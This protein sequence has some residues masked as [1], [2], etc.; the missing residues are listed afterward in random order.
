LLGL[1]G[2]GRPSPHNLDLEK[3][4]LLA[5]VEM[6]NVKRADAGLKA[7]SSTAEEPR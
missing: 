2:R 5:S 1:D 6:A 7:A 4:R 3:D